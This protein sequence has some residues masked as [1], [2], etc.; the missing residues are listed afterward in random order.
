MGLFNKKNEGGLMDVI[1]C[2]EKEYL[3]W[4]WRPAGEDV[5]ST[6]KEN[7]IRYGSSLRVKDGEVAVFVYPGENGNQDF[8]EGPFDQTIKT[9]NFPVLS[10]I[11][12]AAFGGASPFQAEIYFINL[13][14]L[15]QTR[16]AVPYFDIADPRFLDFTVPVAVRGDIRFKITDYKEFIKLHRLINFDLEDFK[17]QI[18]SAV[19]KYV[20]GV[21]ANIP[22]E[23]GIPVIQLERKLTEINDVVEESLKKRL[24]NEFGITV[25]SVDIDAIDIDKTSDGYHNLK[26]VTQDVT[27][28]TIQRQTNANLTNM[29][30][31]LRIQRE[32][33]AQAQRLQNESANLSAFQLEKQAEV[34]VEG[35]KAFGQMGANDAGNLNLGGG[36]GMNPAGMMAGMAM[37]SAIGQN[38]AGMVGGMMN[39]MNQQVAPQANNVP[40]VPGNE[41]YHVAVNGTATGPYT[42]S[43]LSTMAANGQFTKESLVWKSGMANW[44]AAGSISELAGL[45]AG[46]VPPVPPVPPQM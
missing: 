29:E 43:V 5:N 7:A 20:K 23:K 3:I 40:P 31:N 30:E 13:A 37:G 14:G 36:L 41:S 1:R 4:K 21:V 10:S 2:D 25:G 19:S 15:I 45:F 24:Q 39:G 44:Q 34:G 46:T 28:Q 26:A 32:G 11:V 12:G 9:G 35:A 8:I 18:K 6:K 17:S 16:F 33:M 22:S 27:T 38:M 42:V